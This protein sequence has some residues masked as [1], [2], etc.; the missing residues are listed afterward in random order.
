METCDSPQKFGKILKMIRDTGDSGVYIFGDSSFMK[1]KAIEIAIERASGPMQAMNRSVFQGTE[2]KSTV[3]LFDQLLQYP[4]MAQE[5]VVVL[6]DFNKVPKAVREKIADF[7]V[8]ST[9]FFVVEEE[10][11]DK[12]K[13]EYKKLSKKLLTIDLSEPRLYNIKP[14]AEYFANKY[15]VRL[16]REA[17]DYIVEHAAVSIDSLR[18]E[19]EKI[20]LL[21]Q[22]RLL[23][24]KD[25]EEVVSHSLSKNRFDFGDALRDRNPAL[26]FET[27]ENMLS[28]G[29]NAGSLLWVLGDELQKLA[30]LKAGIEIRMNPYILRKYQSS[31]RAFS[32]EELRAGLMAAYR[33]DIL[34][35]SGK[36]KD[37]DAIYWALGEIISSWKR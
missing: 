31:V 15:K 20:S 33:A 22:D 9:S 7:D 35:K 19:M 32:E 21:H 36:M 12:R 11:P 24:K 13:A 2:L 14:W 17:L 4:S 18:A 5:R 27:L 3:P 8:P 6:R 37:T 23:V 30:M 16:N 34:I 28:F 26:V 1:E 25:I 29:E 10:K